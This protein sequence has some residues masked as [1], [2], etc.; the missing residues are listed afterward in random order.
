[1]EPAQVLFWG[2]TTRIA[3]NF[4]KFRCFVAIHESFLCKIWGRGVLW[5]GKSEQPVKFFSSKIVFFTNLRIFF[6]QMFPAIQYMYMKLDFFIAAH[7]TSILRKQNANT[8]FILASLLV[9]YMY[10]F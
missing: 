6:P 2:L 5:C 7:M 3:E 9:K 1:M 10:E 8:F 4:C